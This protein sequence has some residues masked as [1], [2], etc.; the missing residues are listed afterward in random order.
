MGHDRHHRAGRDDVPRRRA[1]RRHHL[2][3]SGLATSAGG[4]SP[5]SGTASA[6]TISAPP[7]PTPTTVTAVPTSATEIEL[8][9]TD[10]ANE[11]GYR[12]ER[13]PD[14]STGWATIAM[15]G[16]NVT[17]HMDGGLAAG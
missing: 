9:W 7:T 11:T 5:A 16:P 14:G 17:T 13:S 6:T 8:D 1:V 3:L 2:L 12:V 10:V 4:D 15:T